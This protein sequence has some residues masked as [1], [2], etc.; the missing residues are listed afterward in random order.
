[1]SRGSFF[2][3]T[4][5]NSSITKGKYGQSHLELLQKKYRRFRILYQM[6]VS[7]LFLGNLIFFELNAFSE[8]K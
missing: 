2:S 4:N 1:M 3:K 6:K 7:K 5:G 8:Q